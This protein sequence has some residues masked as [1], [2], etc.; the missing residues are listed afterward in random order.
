[1]CVSS[2][3]RSL[4]WRCPAHAGM[5][6]VAA[7]ST[8]TRIRARRVGSMGMM[9]DTTCKSLAMEEKNMVGWTKMRL[10]SGAT[11]SPKGSTGAGT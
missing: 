6:R 3:G 8:R 9:F 1:M 5:A 4:T 7:A 10:G 2:G 11:Q